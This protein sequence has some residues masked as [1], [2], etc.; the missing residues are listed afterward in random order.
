MPYCTLKPNMTILFQGDSITDAGRE[1]GACS[2]LL[3][4]TASPR[5]LPETAFI[6]HSPGTRSWPGRGWSAGSAC[7]WRDVSKTRIPP[8][9]PRS[10]SAVH[11]SDRWDSAISS[12]FSATRTT[13]RGT[14]AHAHLVNS[15]AFEGH[16]VS[17]R[18]LPADR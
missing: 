11:V 10:P 1:G 14:V 7:Q 2:P 15:R 16:S 6:R 3:W 8:R 9:V 13:V 18:P 17:R 4:A 5:S 12:C